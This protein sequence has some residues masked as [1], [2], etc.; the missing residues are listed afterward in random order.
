MSIKPK[1]NFAFAVFHFGSNI[2]Y[3]ELAMYFV[4][5]LR[6]H[7]IHDIIWLYSEY[8]TPPSFVTEMQP[9]VTSVR[10]YNDSGILVDVPSTGKYTAFSA[11]RTCNFMYAFNLTE[12]SKVCVIETDLVILKSINSIFKLRA[13]AI[14][15]YRSHSKLGDEPIHPTY[16][17]E[18]RHLPSRLAKLAAEQKSDFNGGVILL[19]PNT[20]KFIECI[21][22]IKYIIKMQ[23]AYPNES[24]FQYIFPVHRNLPVMYNLIHF[25]I[26]KINKSYKLSQRQIIAVHF[27]ESRF[28]HIDVVKSEELTIE[29]KTKARYD[30][31][32]PVIEYFA[33]HVFFPYQLEVENALERVK[34]A[35]IA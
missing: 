29:L 28:K 19:V 18:R 26:H 25:T 35:I 11:L 27:N 20:E 17:K 9:L 12:Y 22:S 21:N 2:A 24:L 7:T 23:F 13:P 4:R 34:L 5:N 3:L 32:A 10:S 30:C 8:D 16:N 6:M 31:I 15:T 33:T 14:V 1:S